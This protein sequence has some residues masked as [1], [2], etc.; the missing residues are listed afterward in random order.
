MPHGTEKRQLPESQPSHSFQLQQMLGRLVWQDLIALCHKRSLGRGSTSEERAESV[1]QTS[2][3]VAPTLKWCGL[4]EMVTGWV[5]A[6]EVSS[7]DQSHSSRELLSWKSLLEQGS[8]WDTQVPYICLYAQSWFQRL[9]FP[10]GVCS[11]GSTEVSVWCFLG[12]LSRALQ[13]ECRQQLQVRNRLRYRANPQKD[14]HSCR[15]LS[16][17][18]NQLSPFHCLTL[19]LLPTNK[20]TKIWSVFLVI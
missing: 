1:P 16:S 10:G 8:S 6:G 18:G 3:A 9:C 12:F 19:H 11:E 5:V 20:E 17:A 13:Q 15:A 7:E 14:E 2:R 4:P